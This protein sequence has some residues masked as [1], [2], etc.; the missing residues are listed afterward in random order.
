MFEHEIT[1]QSK[2]EPNV[3]LF[4]EQFELNPSP[5]IVIKV[6]PLTEPIFGLKL[7]IYSLYWSFEGTLYYKTH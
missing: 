2:D 5:L 7:E 4:S 6:P 1:L 3:T